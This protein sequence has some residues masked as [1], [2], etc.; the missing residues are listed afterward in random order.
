M[1]AR[2]FAPQASTIIYVVHRF[3]DI[4]R[5]QYIF[6]LDYSIFMFVALFFAVF[7]HSFIHCK[8]SGSVG[9]YYGASICQYRWVGNRQS[10][11]TI[12]KTISHSSELDFAIGRIY[13][14][15]NN[16]AQFS[17]IH[18]FAL[19]HSR[20]WKIYFCK[21]SRKSH[22]LQGALCYRMLCY[23]SYR[24]LCHLCYR[25]LCY[26]R[27]VFDIIERACIYN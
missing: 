6:I 3:D 7:I 4:H 22:A 14:S 21:S 11:K 23:L 25:M 15:N 24:M 13:P 16:N 17:A 9:R 1:Q 26:V 20:I 2:D 5:L 10:S 8:E 27:Y 12:Q 19:R 18:A